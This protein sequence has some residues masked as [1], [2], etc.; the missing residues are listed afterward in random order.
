MKK[1]IAMLLT[2]VGSL[3]A[4]AQ[5][6]AFTTSKGILEITPVYHG[7]FYM[8]WNNLVILV[9]PYGGADRY[10]AIGEADLILITDIHGD[11]MDSSTLVKLDLRKATIVAPVAV[12]KRLQQF[13]SPNTKITV[14]SNGESVESAGVNITA[15]PMYNLPYT[16]GVR[17][18]KGRGN[19]YVLQLGDKRL[20]VSGDT[21]DIPEMRSLQ[22]IDIAFLCMNK[23]YTM[24]IK[25]AASATLAFKPTVVYPFHFREPGGFADIQ[26]FS[27]LVKAG[28]QEID[29]RIRK[30]Y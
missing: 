21:E 18:P 3:A 26:E 28:N 19:G 7:S 14:V 12:Q 15:V 20:Y 22:K 27:R 23:P 13:L 4:T 29:V 17:H 25:Q 1:I 6:D 5:V 8:K 9:D 2:L 30:W 16:P 10:Q 24:D 11:H